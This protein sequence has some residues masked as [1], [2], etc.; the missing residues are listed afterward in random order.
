MV[1][2]RLASMVTLR[3]PCATRVLMAP[4]ARLAAMSLHRERIG[5]SAL[6]D[7]IGARGAERSGQVGVISFARGAAA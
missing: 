4:A 1:T 7:P 5:V 6:I 2:L 3:R